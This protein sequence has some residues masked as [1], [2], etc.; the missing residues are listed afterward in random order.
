MSLYESLTKLSNK[1]FP[2]TDVIKSLL[3]ILSNELCTSNLQRHSHTFCTLISRSRDICDY[4]N[5]LIEKSI[6]EDGWTSYD[7]Y[8]VM[9]EP[10]EALLLSVSEV[11]DTSCVETS[12]DT[13]G[14]DEWITGAQFWNIDRKKV[15]DVLGSA[16]FEEMLQSIPPTLMLED[17]TY[18]LKH[19]DDVFMGNLIRGLER[20]LSDNEA[21]STAGIHSRSAQIQSKLKEIHMKVKE[22]TFDETIVIAIKSTILVNGIVEVS[23]KSTVP[24]IRAH[25]RSATVLSKTLELLDA[26]SQNFGRPR[27]VDLEKKYSEFEALL[28]MKQELGPARLPA[29]TRGAPRSFLNLQK[30]PGNIRPPYYL[31]TLVLIQY[32]HT[33]VN[34]YLKAGSELPHKPMD[35]AI[36]E[37]TN[38]LRLAA[39]LRDKGSNRANV[40]FENVQSSEV[41]NAYITAIAAVRSSCK[42][43][44]I[45][46]DA[47]RM[48]TAKENDAKRLK[49]W[50]DRVQRKNMN[51]PLDLVEI[52]VT[53]R[54][55]TFAINPKDLK[56]SVPPTTQLDVILWEVLAHVPHEIQDRIRSRSHFKTGSPPETLSLTDPV[57]KVVGRALLLVIRA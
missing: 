32:C 44:E 10:L 2:A 51:K 31:Q 26:I 18:S 23:I 27:K 1:A 56:F 52:V 53:F 49:A 5:S 50:K 8:T 45:E 47:S 46:F 24:E 30:F 40:D 37:T 12:T 48:N 41:T 33:L 21:K 7:R 43:Y 36:L 42:S 13:S 25:L 35:D 20:R 14:I 55:E 54:D 57:S 4:I 15:K 3:C 34:R 16:F 28:K 39:N 9:I 6:T 11:A 29:G 17:T 19:D 22:S 38:A